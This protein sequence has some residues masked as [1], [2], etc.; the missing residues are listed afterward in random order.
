MSLHLVV[1]SDSL[2]GIQSI[3]TV[4]VPETGR[5]LVGLADLAQYRAVV[6]EAARAAS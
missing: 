2:E 4:V 6:D 3:P 1:Y 5:V